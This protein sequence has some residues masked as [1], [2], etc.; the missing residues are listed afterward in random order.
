MAN[1]ARVVGV[2]SEQ[3]IHHV[4]AGE[5]SVYDV[6]LEV[7]DGPD[8]VPGGRAIEQFEASDPANLRRV[9]DPLDAEYDAVVVDTGAGLSHEA[10]VATGLADRTVLVTTPQPESVADVAK[11]VE[12]VDHADATVAGAVVT[13]T[14]EA[15]DFAG[16]AADLD[17]D[18]VG[19][20]PEDSTVGVEPVTDGDAGAAYAQL[21]A[22]LT[23]FLDAHGPTVEAPQSVD[24]ASP[25]GPVG[26][27][28][29]AVAQ[30]GD[31][32]AADDPTS[33]DSST[34]APADD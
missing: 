24:R 12:F 2:E 28:E 27:D 1:L 6:L 31:E 18:L 15:T 33:P 5:G 34:A 19:A 21:A 23:I 11:T 25:E 3:G 8:V 9:I 14:T 4:L 30:A 22:T 29:S 10:L 17:V 26:E 13:R 32:Q 16:I 20:I 7:D